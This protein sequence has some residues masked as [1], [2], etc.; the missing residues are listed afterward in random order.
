MYTYPLLLSLP[1]DHRHI[2]Y[3]SQYI[4]RASGRNKKKGGVQT[5]RCIK[6]LLGRRKN[7]TK[8]P[9]ISSP[10]TYSLL[11]RSPPFFALH[12]PP[13]ANNVPREISRKKK[14]AMA[15]IG[16]RM[17]RNTNTNTKSS[18]PPDPIYT[19]HRRLNPG[20]AG[21][22]VV[23]ASL[24]EDLTLGH[25]EHPFGEGAPHVFCAVGQAW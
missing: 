23:L 16:S 25:D 17:D 7:Q 5:I 11:L 2:N 13:T 20:V 19:E 3:P 14:K 8:S 12:I 15:I 6:W 1:Q 18:H 21:N 22:A 4:S 24:K 10:A 9:L